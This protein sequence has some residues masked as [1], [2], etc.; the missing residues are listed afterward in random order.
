MLPKYTIQANVRNVASTASPYK[1][2]GGDSPTLCCREQSRKRYFHELTGNSCNLDT[3]EI[4]SYASLVH[5]PRRHQHPLQ[6]NEMIVTRLARELRC[7]ILPQEMSTRHQAYSKLQNPQYIHV[8][9][10]LLP[11]PRQVICTLCTGCVHT[12][13]IPLTPTSRQA[14]LE[15]TPA[16]RPGQAHSC[17]ETQD[18]ART[19]SSTS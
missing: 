7:I 17:K 6:L 8:P 14:R 10:A 2:I 13:P 19:D 16:G 3:N 5:V 11:Q 4:F 15:S 1:H 12:T 18:R 9:W